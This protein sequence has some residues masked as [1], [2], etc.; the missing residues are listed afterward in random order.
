MEDGTMKDSEIKEN[1]R[2]YKN[3]KCA[4]FER[5]AKLSSIKAAVLASCLTLELMGD[6]ASEFNDDLI[7]FLGSNIHK[8]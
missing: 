7:Y 8:D 2:L 3:D 5:L 1:V 6:C 4:F